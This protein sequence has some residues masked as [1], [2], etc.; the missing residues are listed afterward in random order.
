MVVTLFTNKFARK[1]SLAI[2][3]NPTHDLKSFAPQA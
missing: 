1:K 3:R 2:D